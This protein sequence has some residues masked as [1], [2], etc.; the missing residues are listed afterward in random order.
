MLLLSLLMTQ[1]IMA[2]TLL[3]LPSLSRERGRG[4]IKRLREKAVTSLRRLPSSAIFTC[5]ITI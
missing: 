2:T 4:D 3:F 5:H 1:V